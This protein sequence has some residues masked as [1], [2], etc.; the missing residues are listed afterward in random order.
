MLNT[1]H[2]AIII[3]L[4]VDYGGHPEAF[5]RPGYRQ[6]GP[7]EDEDRQDE[8]EERSGNYVVEDDDKVAQHL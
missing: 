2:N 7:E 1:P 5:G 8:G 3:Y 4:C 6:H